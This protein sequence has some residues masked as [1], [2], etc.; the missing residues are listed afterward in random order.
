MSGV[1]AATVSEVLL[2]TVAVPSITGASY[3]QVDAANGLAFVVAGGVVRCYDIRRNVIAGVSSGISSDVRFD[4][5]ANT[6]VTATSSTVNAMSYSYNF[7]IPTFS[8][9]FSFSSPA[10]GGGQGLTYTLVKDYISSYLIIS[11]AYNLCRYDSNSVSG[12]TCAGGGGTYTIPSNLVQFADNYF[13]GDGDQ[14]GGQILDKTN[15]NTNSYYYAFK[16]GCNGLTSER[17]TGK[18]WIL[19]FELYVIVPEWNLRYL[20]CSGGGCSNVQV[21]GR[22][23]SMNAVEV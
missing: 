20:S 7:D 22:S 19:S 5:A 18:V 4:V 13:L 3:A 11:A 1:S 12:K 15:M 23:N 14:T 6:V 10:S 17:N 2:K 21:V 8:A 16:A 9:T